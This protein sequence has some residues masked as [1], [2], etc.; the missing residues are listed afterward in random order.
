MHTSFG[1]TAKGQ[2]ALLY[3]IQNHHGMSA[4][5]TNFG[6]AVVSLFVPVRNQ[7][8]DVVLGYDC[9]TGYEDNPQAMGCCIGRNANRT[10]TASFMLDGKRFL[11]EA[12][13]GGNNLHSSLTDGYHKRI[14]ETVSESEDS[15]CLRMISPD[16]DQGFPGRCITTLTYTITENNSLQIRY[17]G[18]SN[19]RTPWNPTNHSYFNLAGHD[20][21]SMED[22][23]LQIH[24]THFTPLDAA[25]ITT[26]EILPVSSTPMDFTVP[27]AIGARIEEN[28]EPL[29]MAGGYDHNYCLN[30]TPGS[31]EK[32][33]MAFSPKTGLTMETWTD[34]PGVQFYT[35]NFIQN[36]RGK[37]GTIYAD[38]SGFCLETQQ[39][40]DSVN[41]PHFP[42]CIL[43][44]DTPCVTT[45][46]YHFA[47]K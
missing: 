22:T 36:A 17:E 41:K 35:G 25:S 39:Y 33:S 18:I 14:W 16:G 23:L 15:L 34:R 30:V 2:E 43:E 3:T 37:Q 31:P 40:P 12:N 19:K 46:M 20:S 13:E 10:G 26:G 4:R 27:T 24:A 45:T 42:S 28:Y 29:T 21:G 1:T 8:L 11:L 38:R 32:I 6:A 44:A 47:C 9:V 7:T 5:I